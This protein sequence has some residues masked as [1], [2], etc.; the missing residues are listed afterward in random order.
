MLY[1][2]LNIFFPETW[3]VPDHHIAIQ[4]VSQP[5]KE[6]WKASNWLFFLSLFFCLQI[7]LL[8]VMACDW[9]WRP[10]TVLLYKQSIDVTILLSQYSWLAHKNWWDLCR[11][12][13]ILQYVLYSFE[14]LYFFILLFVFLNSVSFG[15]EPLQTC[16]LLTGR[17][18]FIVFLTSKA[19]FLLGH[20]SMRN[21]S[22]FT[23]TVFMTYS[24]PNNSLNR[25]SSY[26]CQPQT[27]KME[28]SNTP[29]KQLVLRILWMFYL[30]CANVIVWEL[31]LQ[32]SISDRVWVS[33][34]LPLSIDY[35]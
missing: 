26:V 32:Q 24:K 3:D 31:L 18:T 8:N 6:T 30:L 20:C 16:A 2:P 27:K 23:H 4:R 29:V 28:N 21:I 13:F 35:D 11:L 25:E 17:L 1:S 10:A 9:K 12:T 22:R 14:H 34:Y 5:V 33:A 19:I 15:V 7:H